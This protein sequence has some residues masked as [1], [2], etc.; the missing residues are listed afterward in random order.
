[1]HKVILV[2]WENGFPLLKSQS[3]GR[4]ESSSW[5]CPMINKFRD[6]DIPAACIENRMQANVHLIR[7]FFLHKDYDGESSRKGIPCWKLLIDI[8][9]THPYSRRPGILRYF[10]LLFI[11]FSH[12]LRC[13]PHHDSALLC[14][15]NLEVDL[16]YLRTSGQQSWVTHCSPPDLEKQVLQQFLIPFAQKNMVYSD[17]VLISIGPLRRGHTDIQSIH[18]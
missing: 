14:Q 11:C 6:I 18:E 13:H 2:I 15:S 9:S 10:F 1:M 17:S 7:A 3:S 12:H 8:I 16:A 5:S 4:D